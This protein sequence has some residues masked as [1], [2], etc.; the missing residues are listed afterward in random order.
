MN[1]HFMRHKHRLGRFV[2]QCGQF[3]DNRLTM[4]TFPLF[5]FRKDRPGDARAKLVKLLREMRADTDKR[6][7]FKALACF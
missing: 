5:L 2:H 4:P 7:K 3:W 1:A 6:R